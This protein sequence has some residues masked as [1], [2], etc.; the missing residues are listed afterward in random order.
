M[1]KKSLLV[2]EII[3]I[4]L[5]LYNEPEERLQNYLNQIRS[6]LRNYNYIISIC[7]NYPHNFQLE[8]DI[9][10]HKMNKNV[11][12][13]RGHNLN[14]QFLII[15]GC[16]KIIVSNT[17][18][19]LTDSVKEMLQC[20]GPIMI[21]PIILNSDNSTQKVIRAFPS[22]F[23]KVYSFIF[24]YP[25]FLDR[26]NFTNVETIV[27]SVSGC[28]F[29]IDVNRYSNLGFNLLFDEKYFMYEEDTDLCRRLW[30]HRGVFV[31][32]LAHIFHSY[33]KGSSKKLKLFF[34]HLKSIWVYFWKWGFFDKASEESNYLI[35]SI[36]KENDGCILE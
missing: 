9:F 29:I 4:S 14:Y 22:I 7:E 10:V 6:L 30:P 16:T 27:P 18:I 3:G 36:K 35:E 8:N 20:E 19:I 23:T 2:K 33:E 32:S 21:A 12:Y 28:F 17:D 1:V 5:V 24:D 31:Y 11:G 15:Q 13:G 26:K 34:I 25:N